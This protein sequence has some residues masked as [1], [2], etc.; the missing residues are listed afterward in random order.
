LFRQ[1]VVMDFI[2]WVAF[3]VIFKAMMHFINV[4]TRRNGWT[5]TAGVTG[6]LA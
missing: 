4:E 5:T 1:S 6:L 2:T 3:Y